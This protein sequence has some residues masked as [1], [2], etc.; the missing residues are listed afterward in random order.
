M[1]NITNFIASLK[2][3]W[4]KKLTQC[5]SHGWIFLKQ[6]TAMILKKDIDF[7]DVFLYDMLGSKKQHIFA[8]CV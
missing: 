1:V 8:R 7:G 4:I 2:C 6:S 5:H 3:T